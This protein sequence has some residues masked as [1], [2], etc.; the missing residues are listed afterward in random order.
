MGMVW[1]SAVR[2][3]GVE[4]GSTWAW[5]GARQYVGMVWNSAVRGHGVELS[6][7]WA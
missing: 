2:G 7:T 6:S 3:H 5:C 1:S 4:L